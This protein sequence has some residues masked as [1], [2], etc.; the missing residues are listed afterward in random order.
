MRKQQTFTSRDRTGRQVR[1]GLFIAI[2]MT[3]FAGVASA[4]IANGS[5]ESGYDGWTL[6]EAVYDP[7]T[8]PPFD[9]AGGTWGLGVSGT[10]IDSANPDAFDYND[11]ILVT[12]TTPALN[13]GI[14]WQATDGSQAAFHLQN[15]SGHQ[16]LSQDI[17]LPANVTHIEWDM[18]YTD[19][20]GGWDTF[21]DNFVAVNLRDPGT[22][23]LVAELFRTA[24]GSA[25]SI[26]M[27]H[28]MVDVSAFAGQFVRLEVEL[29]NL[30]K[31]D[32][33]VDN[34]QVQ[35]EGDDGGGGPPPTTG[36]DV[37]IQV[38]DSINPRSNGVVAV[39][40]LGTA[41]FDPTVM[42][43][44]ANLSSGDAHPVHGGH[45]ADVNGDGFSDLLV[46][47]SVQELD[48]GGGVQP[49][50]AGSGPE[51]CLSG[52]TMDNSPIGGCAPVN[53]VGGGR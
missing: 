5:F 16:T 9:P 13:P 45:H 50:A 33:S 44:V 31:V 10:T 39:A 11:N 8:S 23:G 49:L 29:K 42:V 43:D 1:L 7:A 21:G 32:L 15:Q 37:T 26:P 12:Q 22:N 24:P 27:T 30:W 17:A 4:Q 6:S 41:D 48:L 47:F 51:L 2:I 46:H 28:F 35:P 52:Q 18:W 20:I 38:R 25:P 14:T 34:F 36:G 19:H 3:V 40:L 53:L